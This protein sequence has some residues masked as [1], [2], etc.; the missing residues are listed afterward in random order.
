MQA[1]ARDELVTIKPL[2]KGEVQ[3]LTINTE[4]QDY[5]EFSPYKTKS[6][7]KNADSAPKNKAKDDEQPFSITKLLRPTA[8]LFPVFSTVNEDAQKTQ[9][10]TRKDA[11]AIL[12]K[13]VELKNLSKQGSKTVDLDLPLSRGAFR[14]QKPEGTSVTKEELATRFVSALQENYEIFREGATSVVYVC[15]LQFQFVVYL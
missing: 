6:G 9:L 13:Y 10:Y 2:P 11:V 8:D 4:H 3:I 1:M 5:I 12:W 7:K 15:F 14:K